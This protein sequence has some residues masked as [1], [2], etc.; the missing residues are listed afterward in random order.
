MATP[1][2][3]FKPAKP[4]Y[5]LATIVG[6]GTVMLVI[7]AALVL[8]G[9]YRM[10]FDTA[11]LMLV[12]GG[13]FA[14]TLMATTWSDFN[15]TMRVL[16]STFSTTSIE[17]HRYARQLIDLALIARK[18]GVVGL[19]T[20]ESSLRS[21]GFLMRAVRLVADGIKPEEIETLLKQEIDSSLNR[22]EQ[23]VR[24]LRRASDVAPAMGLI[25]TLVG[26]V[27]MLAKLNDPGTIGPSMALALLTTFYGAIL[28]TVILTPLATKLEKR[29]DEDL[30]QKVLALSAAL[31][32]ARL[33]NPRLLEIQ[34]N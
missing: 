19:Q 10:F 9:Q 18:Q 8:G 15:G 23:A 30:T 4:Q 16:K 17:Q 21:D 26:L 32:M 6:L 22:Q 25:G 1:S 3:N 2:F 14:I 31:S 28:G 13:T 29:T 33:E 12:L 7:G 5:D 24:L 11:S 20:Y 27:Q 34:L